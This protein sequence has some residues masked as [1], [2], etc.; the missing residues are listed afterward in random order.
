MPVRLSALVRSCSLASL[1]L[2]FSAWLLA[3]APQSVPSDLPE[4]ARRAQTAVIARD[5]D[6]LRTLA[7]PDALA[8]L[9]PRP[10]P[11]DEHWKFHLV[12]LPGGAGLAGTETRA[13]ASAPDT[14]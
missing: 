4:L 5:W 8:W 6:S 11:G 9:S 10:R 13:T 3:R 7:E 1:C 14:P 12:E 2:P